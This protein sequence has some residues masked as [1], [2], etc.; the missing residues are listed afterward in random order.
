MNLSDVKQIGIVGGGPATLMLCF[1]AAKLGISTCILD[2]KVDCIGA[3]VATEHIVASINKENIKKLSLRCDKVIFNIKPEFELDMKLHAPIYPSKES[4]NEVYDTK[5]VWDILELL[6]IPTS[7]IYYQDS[8]QETFAKIEGLQMPFRFIKQ[9][10]GYCKTMD[11]FSK[12]DLA[13][14]ILEIDEGVQS[15][16]L[17]PIEEYK[18][19]ISCICLV[20]EQG[21]THL[22][23]PIEVKYEDE[24]TYGLR[25][26][27]SLT[28]TMVNRLNRYNRKLL[29][30]INA[31]GVYTVRYGIKSNKSVEFI[32]ITP[33]LGVGGLLTLE[34][35]DIS[36]YEQYMKLA[37]DMKLVVPELIAY[38]HGTIKPTHEVDKED[39]GHV[40]RIAD[41]K[42]C[43]NKEKKIIE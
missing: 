14:F 9:F 1:E 25:I 7:K 6:E 8:K 33:E 24:D 15:F 28:K 30:E 39:T 26:S 13:D 11:I 5:N 19:T 10:E 3:A 18:Q 32:D 22:Y 38:A 34:A 16:I 31:T 37:L 41:H 23:Y 17:Q 27:D 40:Y 36:I 4:L 2:P 29:K 43:V 21:K 42:M 35:Y 20:D 12:E